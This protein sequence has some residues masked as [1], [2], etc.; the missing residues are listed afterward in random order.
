MQNTILG[1][2]VLIVRIPKGEIDKFKI[3]RVL[4]GV[5]TNPDSCSPLITGLVLQ[6]SPF[7]NWLL[8]ASQKYIPFEVCLKIPFSCQL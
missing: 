4:F 8:P 2:F 7:L 1:L 3:L 5:K 6:L